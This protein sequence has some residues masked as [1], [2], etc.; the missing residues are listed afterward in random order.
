MN[1]KKFEYN[2]KDRPFLIKDIRYRIMFIVLCL[3][4]FIWQMVIILT[5]T[6]SD[7][8]KLAIIFG[9]ITMIL[10]VLLILSNLLYVSKSITAIQNIKKHGHSV[11][12]VLLLVKTNK[13]SFIKIYQKITNIFAFII[14]LMLISVA[15]YTILQV[16]YLST[17]S[18][19][20]PLLYLITISGFLSVYHIKYEIKILNS[21]QT[22]NAI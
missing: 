5:H 20:L 1:S 11:D 17:Y 14:T 21:V 8:S 9:I 3:L 15:T 18:L 6:K 19:Y 10:S 7:I 16:I 2:S 22:Y 4:V 12:N 13:S